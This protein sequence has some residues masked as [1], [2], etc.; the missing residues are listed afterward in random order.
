MTRRCIPGSYQSYCWE[1]DWGEPPEGL[2]MSDIQ[3]SS[4]AVQAIKQT[5]VRRLVV[6]RL[7]PNNIGKSWGGVQVHHNV[8]GLHAVK[9]TPPAMQLP[10]LPSTAGFGQQ[11]LQECVLTGIPVCYEGINININIRHCSRVSRLHNT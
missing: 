2:D 9:G 1:R 4:S 8:G 6:W 5:Q 10:D 11:V 3:V 7:K